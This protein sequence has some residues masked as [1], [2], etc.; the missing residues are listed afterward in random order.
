MITAGTAQVGGSDGASAAREA[1][2]RA[3]ARASTLHADLAIA[4]VTPDHRDALPAI[5]ARVREQTHAEVVLAATVAGTMTLEGE[6]ED[7]HGVA[8]MVLGGELAA[9]PFLVPSRGRSR[10]AGLAIGAIAARGASL[11]VLFADPV[12]LD[13][14]AL[15]EGFAEAAPDVRVAGAGLAGDA[16]GALLA[17]GD[18]IVSGH[19]AGVVFGGPGGR[20]RSLRADVATSE[21]CRPLAAPRTITTVAG[22]AI[23]TIDDRPA[24]EA[25]VEAASDPALGDDPRRAAQLVLVGLYAGEGREYLARPVVGFD[26]A[27]GGLVV[28]GQPRAGQRIAFTVREAIGARDDLRVRVREGLAR[29][30][31][32]P[33]FGFYFNCVGRGSNLYGAQNVDA[34]TLRQLLGD[35]PLLGCFSNFELAT[36]A[37]K[38]EMHLF[39]GVAA[40]VAG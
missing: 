11:V 23:L 13:P 9:R 12:G 26:P 25:F 30:G 22:N 1:A 6:I 40:L 31:A 16:E 32:P 19:V 27:R 37:G 14:E 35:L 24:L 2:R 4:L 34:T 39:S 28:A 7:E 15:L 3:M 38:A 21:A 29:L 36:T 20:G 18:R 10:E 17:L 8:V 33:A 5:V